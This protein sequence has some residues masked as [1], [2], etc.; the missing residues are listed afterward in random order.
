MQFERL[1]GEL[2]SALAPAFLLVPR[3]G[4]ESRFIPVKDHAELDANRA[5][6]SARV[7]P[8]LTAAEHQRHAP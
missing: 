4:P 3:D 7:A 1:I 5:A 2:T 8:Y 6:I